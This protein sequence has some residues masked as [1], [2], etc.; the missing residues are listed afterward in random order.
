MKSSLRE[1][2][3]QKHDCKTQTTETSDTNGIKMQKS[4]EETSVTSYDSSD[5]YFAIDSPLKVDTYTSR[6]YTNNLSIK[7]PVQEKTDQQKNEGTYKADSIDE[8]YHQDKL[9]GSNKPY[10]VVILGLIDD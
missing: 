9:Y 10:R 6:S 5:P 2:Y 1:F 7:S 3:P 8:S 4:I